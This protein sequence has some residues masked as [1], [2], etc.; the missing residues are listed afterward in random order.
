[1]LSLLPHGVGSLNNDFKEKREKKLHKVLNV[2]TSKSMLSVKLPKGVL[3]GCHGL[4]R[5]S[6]CVEWGGGWGR[7]D[8]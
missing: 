6:V 3:I 5:R 4:E 1:M 8:L 7:G 2:R